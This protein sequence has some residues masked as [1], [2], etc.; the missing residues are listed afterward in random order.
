VFHDFCS[1][2]AGDSVSLGYNAT[3]LGNR[4]VSDVLR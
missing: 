2:V 3:S 1:S 4:S